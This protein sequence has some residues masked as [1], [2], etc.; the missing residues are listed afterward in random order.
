MGPFYGAFLTPH[1]L[2][3]GLRLGTEG[4]RGSTA[5]ALGLGMSEATWSPV[6]ARPAL[7][8]GMG[9]GSRSMSCLVCLAITETLG[10]REPLK[11]LLCSPPSPREEPQL[12]LKHQKGSSWGGGAGRCWWQLGEEVWCGINGSR[13]DRGGQIQETEPPKTQFPMRMKR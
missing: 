11:S 8:A 2:P 5:L 10:R 13:G 1:P 4:E 7:L 12:H 6:T 3:S 9:I